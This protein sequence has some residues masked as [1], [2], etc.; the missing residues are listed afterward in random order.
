MGQPKRLQQPTGTQGDASSGMILRLRG[1]DGSGERE[2]RQISRSREGTLLLSW[3][4]NGVADAEDGSST[5]K[6]DEIVAFLREADA[7]GEHVGG[8][9]FQ[10]TW[11]LGD[12]ALDIEGYEWYG[13]NR[14]EARSTPDA[15]HGSAGVGWLLCKE[16]VKNGNVKVT[17]PTYGDCEGLVI[18][19]LRKENKIVTL[20]NAYRELKRDEFVIDDEAFIKGVLG[21][22]EAARDAPSNEKIEKFTYLLCDANIRV[23]TLRDGDGDYRGGESTNSGPLARTFVRAISEAGAAIVHGRLCQFGYTFEPVGQKRRSVCDYVI[24]DDLGSVIE[25][26]VCDRETADIGS[27]HNALYIRADFAF[28]EGRGRRRESGGRSRGRGAGCPYSRKGLSGAR[29]ALNRIVS[30]VVANTC[31]S[32]DFDRVNDLDVNWTLWKGMMLD[33][34]AEVAPVTTATSSRRRL[35]CWQPHWNVE[36]MLLREKC[37][38][39]MDRPL[40]VKR[41][42]HDTGAL[43]R[44]YKDAR[45]VMKKSARDAKKAHVTKT[46]AFLRECASDPSKTSLFWKTVLGRASKRMSGVTKEVIELRI[47]ERTEIHRSPPERVETHRSVDDK[48]VAPRTTRDPKEVARIFR[49]EFAKIGSD[50]PPVGNT[51][52][53]DERA[54]QDARVAEILA[55]PVYDGPIGGRI[56]R[57]EIARC[58]RRLKY[59][60]AS[61]L[62]FVSTDLLKLCVENVKFLGSLQLIFNQCLEAGRGP[63]DWQMAAVT[64]LFKKGERH[65]WAN[66]RLISLLSCVGKLFEAVLARRL[67]TLLDGRDASGEQLLSVYQGGFRGGRRCQHHAWTLTEAIKYAARRGKR[68]YAAFLDVRKA[69]PTT[70]RSAMLERLFDKLSRCGDGSRRCRVWTVIEKMLRE[71]NCRSKVIVDGEASDEYTVGHGL[72]EGA[73]LSPI[74]YAVFIDEIARELDGCDGVTVGKERIRCLLYA[75]D[76]VLLSESADG[77]QEMLDRCQRFA[78]RSSFQFSM[79][80]SHV[81]IF[82][83]HAAGAGDERVF[84]IMGKPMTRADEYTYLGL[85]LHRSLGRTERVREEEKIHAKYVGKKF[86]DVDFNEEERVIRSVFFCNENYVWIAETSRLDEEEADVRYF[87]NAESKMD[88]MIDHF[89]GKYGERQKASKPLAAWDLQKQKLREKLVNKKHLLRRLGCHAHGLDTP[90]ARLVAATMCDA[91]SIQNAEIWQMGQEASEIQTEMNAIHRTILGAE[92]RTC[93]SAVRHELGCASQLVRSKEAALRFRN[94]VLSLDAADHVV[95]RIYDELKRDSRG[96]GATRNGVAGYLELL[97]KDAK[98]EQSVGVSAAKTKGRAFVKE[99]QNDNLVKDLTDDRSTLRDMRRW[100]QVDRHGIPAYLKRSCPVGLRGGRRLK[101]KFRLGRH[102]LQSSLACMEVTKDKACKCCSRKVPETVMHAMLDC[103]AHDAERRV[104][105]TRM[106]QLVPE[107]G[108]KTKDEQLKFLMGDAT[109]AAVDSTLYRYLISLSASRERWLGIPTAQ[110]VGPRP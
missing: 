21:E 18:V 79:G 36:T 71:G 47:P 63:K 13:R 65:D 103:E 95:R 64:C 57:D 88:R 45:K 97:A 66:Y 55:M 25:A 110:G 91:V 93:T 51:F 32:G 14:S 108:R 83:D 20:I 16:L 31:A 50:T 98:W 11:L 107:F 10:E 81:V 6:R 68:T 106:D 15:P 54:R 74:L 77:L 82:G 43:E 105:L 2:R 94:N 75:D 89:S 84:K 17:R 92:S 28:S 67:S 34:A 24:T 104:F 19:T 62:D 8:I 85:V 72:R 22:L 23:G 59:G 38:D 56:T 78:D 60:K 40:E 80:K 7:R 35:S 3:N 101:T 4:A 12:D 109:P 26:G 70:R 58:I 53:M 90:T 37:R 96:C 76:I 52:D 39:I 5:V 99:K 86:L 29:E 27:D 87:L 42:G 46:N 69:Y 48:E 41:S 9:A 61:G 33:A 1:G 30:R 49:D 44:E 102:Q 100:V 73:V